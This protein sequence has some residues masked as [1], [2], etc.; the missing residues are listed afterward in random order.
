VTDGGSSCDIAA[1]CMCGGALVPAGN[2][3]ADG[4]LEAEVTS[5]F[6]AR[7]AA[8][9]G[10]T[11]GFAVGDMICVDQ[12]VVGAT[13]LVPVQSGGDAA[14]VTLVPDGET[15]VP[16]FAYTVQLDDGGRPLACNAGI[17]SQL[18]L[19]T[20]QAVDALRAQDCAAS[21]GAV[22]AR[23]TGSACAPPGGCSAGW[24]APGGWAAPAA[25]V[26]FLA[27]VRWIERRRRCGSTRR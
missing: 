8:T 7:V 18:P 11:T 3:P 13:I 24:A 10:D 16:N 15:C 14:H 1:A 26:A 9:F 21:L 2:V 6:Q 19:T 23:W 22:D 20:Q 27:A 25:L 17:E 12:S 5:A 4:V